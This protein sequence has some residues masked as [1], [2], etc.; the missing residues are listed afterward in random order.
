[1]LI[2]IHLLLLLLPDGRAPGGA[3]RGRQSRRPGPGQAASGA[4]GAG[5]PGQE[6]LLTSTPYSRFLKSC[7]NVSPRWINMVKLHSSS[8]LVW[9]RQRWVVLIFYFIRTCIFH[10]SP[11]QIVS[12]LLESPDLELN[13]RTP[14][15]WTA[16]VAA[17]DKVAALWLLTVL[18]FL[19]RQQATTIRRTK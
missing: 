13:A 2:L 14:E 18:E 16:L 1:M 6:L 19:L 17:A 10:C 11:T 3:V 7:R 8:R 12:C 5:Q 9:E 4:R 15:G